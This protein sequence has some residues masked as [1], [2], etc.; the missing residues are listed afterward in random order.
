MSHRQYFLTGISVELLHLT[1][2]IN[3]ASFWGRHI[4][5]SSLWEAFLFIFLEIDIFRMEVTTAEYWFIGGC[6]IF[7]NT[8]YALCTGFPLCSMPLRAKGL[9]QDQ[10]EFHI[11]ASFAF[12]FFA[13]RVMRNCHK[14]LDQHWFFPRR[15]RIQIRCCGTARTPT[16]T[17]CY[18]SARASNSLK[19]LGDNE[20][21]KVIVPSRRQQ[22]KKTREE[23]F[24]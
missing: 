9:N 17:C 24:F 21:G 15:S 2:R 6:K 8:F 16:L 19:S 10:T 7:S 12:Y 20:K 4:L 18:A 22:V 5:S 3:F 14:F 1:S 11:S 13:K 23:C